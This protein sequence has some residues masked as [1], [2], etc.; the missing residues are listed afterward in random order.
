MGNI[1]GEPFDDCWVASGL[2]AI[3]PPFAADKRDPPPAAVNF[4]NKPMLFVI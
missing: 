2:T 3:A 1:I 4:V